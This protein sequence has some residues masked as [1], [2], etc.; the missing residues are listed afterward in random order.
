MAERCN[1]VVGSAGKR[2]PCIFGSQPLLPSLHK[3]F[4]TRH[5]GR[6]ALLLPLVQCPLTSL[7][8][9][10]EVPHKGQVQVSAAI[11]VTAANADMPP[12]GVPGAKGS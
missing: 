2:Q 1:S 5:L 4:L 7:Y 9:G 12:S 8:A 6:C 11:T 3:P 10:E